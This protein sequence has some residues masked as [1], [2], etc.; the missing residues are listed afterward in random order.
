MPHWNLD[1]SA[2]SLSHLSLYAW[3]RLGILLCRCTYIDIFHV[4]MPHTLYTGKFMVYV[5]LCIFDRT[6]IIDIFE[7]C[8]SST[9]S[10]FSFHRGKNIFGGGEMKWFISLGMKTEVRLWLFKVLRWI[11]RS[12]SSFLVLIFTTTVHIFFAGLY[13]RCKCNIDIAP[14]IYHWMPCLTVEI[15]AR[16]NFGESHNPPGMYNSVYLK[17]F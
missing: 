3:W 8:Y 12:C 2:P 14:C 6:C 7:K 16:D 13:I 11:L 10:A 17:I 15:G 9:A 4:Y 1:K 5:D